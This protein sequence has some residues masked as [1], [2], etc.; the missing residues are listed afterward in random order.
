MTDPC[1]IY[2]TDIAEHE[3]T[4]DQLVF[5]IEYASPEER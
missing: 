4:L 5:D 2:D 3:P 1:V